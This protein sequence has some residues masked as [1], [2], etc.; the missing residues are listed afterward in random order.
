[1]GS[2]CDQ[3]VAHSDLDRQASNFEF[4]AW[5]AVSSDSS[6]HSQDVLFAHLCTKVAYK[7]PFIHSHYFFY[8][9]TLELLKMPQK[10]QLVLSYTQTAKLFQ[11][12]E[13]VL[14]VSGM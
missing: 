12:I 4:C 11:W 8:Q 14:I 2:L 1:M 13:V 10:Q 5:R 9:V 3:D 6:C 7:A